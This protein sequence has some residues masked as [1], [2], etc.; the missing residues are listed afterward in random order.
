MGFRKNQALWKEMQQAQPNMAYQKIKINEAVKLVWDRKYESWSPAPDKS[1]R[2]EWVKSIQARMLYSV[3]DLASRMSGRTNKGHPQWIKDMFD[4]NAP[5]AETSADN[6][7]ADPSYPLPTAPA[8][9]QAEDPCCAICGTKLSEKNDPRNR[10]Q[11]EVCDQK[12]QPPELETDVFVHGYN[13]EVKKAYKSKLDKN[14]KVISTSYTKVFCGDNAEDQEF[15]F[16]KFPG[17]KPVAITD[18]TVAEHRAMQKVDVVL[19]K[20]DV[21]SRD[22]DGGTLKLKRSRNEVGIL[23]RQMWHPKHTNSNLLF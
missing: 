14:N 16:A 10:G 15:V 17:C 4:P 2:D 9:G 11:C 20:G 18:L 19:A 5:K 8:A 22:F 12:V 7:A 3:R 6:D 13:R 23:R 21:L 1:F